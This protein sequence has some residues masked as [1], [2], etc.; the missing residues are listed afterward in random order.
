MPEKFGLGCLIETAD[1]DSVV[2]Q[3]VGIRAV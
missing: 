2:S 1:T 3:A